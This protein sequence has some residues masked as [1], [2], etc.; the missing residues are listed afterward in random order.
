VRQ[1]L[2]AQLTACEMYNTFGPLIEN[3]HA[4]I[5]PTLASTHIK[6]DHNPTTPLI[7][8]DQI[9]HGALSW[10]MTPAFNMLSRCPVLSIPSGLA[11]NGIPTSIQIVSKTYDDETVFK[12]GYA[13]EKINRWYDA[14]HR[15]TF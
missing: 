3:Y 1:F 14:E 10:C 9:V 5:C 4:F 6:A 7:I 13:I 11:H 8:N 12:I 15:P 2:D